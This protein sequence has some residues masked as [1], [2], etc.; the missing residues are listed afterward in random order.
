MH[1]TARPV[2]RLQKHKGQTMTE[3]AL[4]LAAIALVA[5]AGF[6]TTGTTLNGAVNAVASLLV[7]AGA[8][9]D[10]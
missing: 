4:I 3:Y 6:K 1:N 2:G 7:G 10:D 9:R 8:P 5:L